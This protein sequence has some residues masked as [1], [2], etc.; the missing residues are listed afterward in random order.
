MI[1]HAVT[2]NTLSPRLFA[3]MPVHLGKPVAEHLEF[4]WPH[5]REGNGELA[6][7]LIGNMNRRNLELV[8]P[9][10]R[11]LVPCNIRLY[12]QFSL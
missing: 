3:N 1:V 12:F 9:G 2:G 10:N 11:Y 5:G 7:R 6:F 4:F 8:F